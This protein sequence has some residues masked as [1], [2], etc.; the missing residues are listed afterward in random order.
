MES[1]NN[2][3]DE[4]IK[5]LEQGILNVFNSDNY[6]NHL[7]VMSKFH[8]YS[9]N[10][11]M[12]IYLQNPN[13]TFLK[14]YKGWQNDFD[15]QVKKGE[16]SITILAPMPIKKDIEVE[17]NDEQG[18]RIKVK[19]TVDL[20]LFKPISVF[21]ISQTQG[22]EIENLHLVEELKFDVSNFNSFFDTLKKIS[23]VNISFENIESGAKG[24][25]HI[26]DNR[27]VINNG[28]SQSQTIKTTMHEIA[29]SILHNKE[30]QAK[31]NPSKE[32]KEIEAESVA[33]IVC[34]HFDIDTSDYSFPYLASWSNVKELKELKASL[35]IIKNTSSEL[36][37]N[38]E[39]NLTKTLELQSK[40]ENIIITQGEKNNIQ[41]EN[42]V[43]K[44]T[45]L[46]EK[47]SQKQKL[48]DEMKTNKH[49][50]SQEI[51]QAK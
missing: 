10:N 24:Y 35:E 2:K 11:Q 9:F 31:R 19:E 7:K 4:T 29:H 17:K 8:N 36:I 23:P 38:I 32:T 12:L 1:K 5:M 28:M 51:K 34:T 6:K 26:V 27:I 22:R 20:L 15:R 48:I 13:A 37:Q 47:L 44:S 50:N 46:K 18:N 3:L 21:D 33:Y 14:T 41:R 45:T 16:K 42:K 49:K 43:S 30:L 39:D 25:Y 40:K